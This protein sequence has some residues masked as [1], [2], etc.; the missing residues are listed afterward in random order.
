MATVAKFT[1]HAWALDAF[2]ELQRHNGT[3]FDILPQLGVI[4]VFAV[5]LIGLAT[6]RMRVTLGRAGSRGLE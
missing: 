5:V 4:A 1:P 3:V 2:A 6:W